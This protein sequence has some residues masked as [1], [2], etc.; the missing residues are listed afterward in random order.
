MPAASTLAASQRQV[1]TSDPKR[2]PVHGAKSAP[3]AGGLR[4]QGYA[5][6]LRQRQP[7]PQKADRSYLQKH[8]LAHKRCSRCLLSAVRLN[9]SACTGPIKL[10]SRRNC[11]RLPLSTGAAMSSVAAN[12]AALRKSCASSASD[13]SL[14]RT[15]TCCLATY[16]N[17]WQF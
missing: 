16:G 2:I 12:A 10:E 14:R 9:K 15:S 17:N 8:C 13:R 4:R 7:A 5:A 3:A 11:V 1:A 6:T